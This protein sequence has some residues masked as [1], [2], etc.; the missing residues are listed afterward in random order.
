M[1]DTTRPKAVFYDSKNTLFDWSQFWVRA[2]EAIIAHYGGSQ[3]G[4]SFKALWHR[5]LIS[6]NHRT[7]FSTYREFTVALE[8]SLE[9][10]MKVM[11]IPGERADVCFMLD[12]WDEVPPFADTVP[13]LAAQQKLARILIFSNVETRYLEMMAGK[14][15]GFTPNFMGSMEQARCCKPSPRAYEWVLEKNGLTPDE[16][17]YCAGPQWDVQ[18]AKALGMRAV[19]LNRSGEALEGVAPDWEIKDLHGVTQILEG[20]EA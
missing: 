19:W 1:N 20:L 11:D 17:I 18:G 7:A 10:A 6:E 9:Y 8:E 14:M 12:L 4:S 16:V 15:D 5:L 13:A 2:S 3:D